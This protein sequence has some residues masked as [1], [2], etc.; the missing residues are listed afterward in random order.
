ML[1]RELKKDYAVEM[2]YGDVPAR[3]RN[4]I[5]SDF[6]SAEN[7]RVLVA[8]PGTMSHGLTL[9]AASCI[10]WYAPTDRTETYLQ[11]NKRID[12]PGQVHATTIVQL[13][14]TAAERE[15]YR[16]LANNES[17]Q[18]LILALAKGKIE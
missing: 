10:V 15:V 3:Q 9:T 2:I 12:R 17:M 5:F 16:R 13:A 14:A 6:M 11:A 18:G 8:D 4:Q 7:P 1:A